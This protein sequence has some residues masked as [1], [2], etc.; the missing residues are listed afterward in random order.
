MKTNLNISFF[1]ILITLATSCSV[2][3]RLY[4]PGYA[5]THKEVISCEKT[6]EYSEDTQHSKTKQNEFQITDNAT[7]EKVD[8]D[9]KNINDFSN[10]HSLQPESNPNL[11]SVSVINS[12]T[13]SVKKKS[14]LHL[15]SNKCNSINELKKSPSNTASS[16]TGVL[17]GILIIILALVLVVI[18]YV[19]YN[20][21]GIFFGTIFFLIFGIAGAIFF[22]FGLIAL[23]TSLAVKNKK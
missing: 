21:L 14:G 4:R 1:L 5:I 16:K 13:I 2:D 18:G 22:I 17:G 7:L 3:K 9:Y 23:I 8:F 6:K 19:F 10:G 20:S 11:N 15:I 12:E